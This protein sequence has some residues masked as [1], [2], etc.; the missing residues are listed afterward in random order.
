MMLCRIGI[1]M[2]NL[3]MIAYDISDHKIRRTVCNHLLDSGSRVQYS[4]FEC[5]LNK[6][7]L[8]VLRQILR[9]LIETT[10]KIRWYPLCKW[11]EADVYWQGTGE[12]IE[13]DEYHLL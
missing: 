3:W 1:C 5:R 12:P 11:C 7:Q 2:S 10:D 13:T 6:K 9:E 8:L 4:V